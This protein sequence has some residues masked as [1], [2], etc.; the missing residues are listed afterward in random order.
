MEEREENQDDKT[1]DPTEER[2]RKFRE[3]GKL[4]SSR[5]IISAA[6]LIFLSG[7]AFF[8]GSRLVS[9]LTSIFSSTWNL[10][11]NVL[12]SNNS[13]RSDVFVA[14]MPLALPIA[15]SIS[16]AATAP[17]L[18]GLGLS[19][20]NWSWK[21]L[22]FDL[23]KINPVQGISNIFGKNIIFETFKSI[24]KA[25]L[26]LSVSYAVIRTEFFK[27]IGFLHSDPLVSIEVAGKGL[28]NLMLAG[29]IATLTI[30]VI[31]FSWNVFTT[32]RQLKMTKDEV[33]KE[34]KYQEGDPLFK[35]QRRRF[36]RDVLL[37]ASIDKV[38]SATFVVTNPTHYSVAI[39][40]ASD[41]QAPIIVSKGQDYMALRIRQIA[42]TNDII[43]VE[44]K[45]LARA[46]YKTVDI[47]QEVPSSLYL[48]VI[49]IL[50][51]IY[52][53]RGRDYFERYGIATRFA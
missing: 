25:V 6:S 32:E 27:S 11:P 43:V 48:A 42:K 29:C 37:R 46:L 51:S 34:I 17:T 18:V 45:M 31:D 24:L 52:R 19:R 28:M 2:R 26:I 20:F 41:L 30:G 9:A 15:I 16:I 53:A 38:S 33:K 23:N 7:I 8:F 36:A 14:L 3:E 44:N 39:R 35:S 22:E 10:I 50:K 12:G 40:Y 47:G 49:E 4:P 13:L 21:K 1:E 5:E